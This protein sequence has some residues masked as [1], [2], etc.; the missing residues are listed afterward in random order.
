MCRCQL[1]D[2]LSQRCPIP[3]GTEDLLEALHEAVERGSPTYRR[4]SQSTEQH[5]TALFGHLDSDARE[6]FRAYEEAL[7]ADTD[8]WAEDR[9][10]L[11]YIA[12]SS[13]LLAHLSE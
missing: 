2:L 1:D 4:E 5:R 11:G 7:N 6:A 8:L 3:E 10:R 9:F 13:G 12:G